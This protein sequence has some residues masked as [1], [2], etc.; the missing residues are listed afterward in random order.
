MEIDQSGMP[1]ETYLSVSDYSSHLFW[2][3]DKTKL[4]LNERKEF[5]M[6]RVLDYGL[7]KDWNQLRADLGLE[8]IGRIA[9][10]LR[11]LDPR[12]ASFIALLTGAGVKT[13]RC[14][15]HQ[16]SSPPHWHF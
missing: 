8:E 10:G 16:Q 13:Y 9:K 4:D 15:I 5:L 14:S 7:M 1:E 3:V 11:S 2:D 12:S 6:N